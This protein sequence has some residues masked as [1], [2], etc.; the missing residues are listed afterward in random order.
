MEND[1]LLVLFTVCIVEKRCGIL[2]IC[3]QVSKVNDFKAKQRGQCH[4]CPVTPVHALH[5]QITTP[6]KY[7][8]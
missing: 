2:V 7:I 8:H 4:H 3:Q 6:M 1:L 5:K